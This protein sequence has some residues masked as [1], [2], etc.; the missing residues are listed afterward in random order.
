MIEDF[1]DFGKLGQGFTSVDELEEV[2]LGGE[3][4]SRPTYISSTLS[5]EHKRRLSDLLKEFPDSFAWS[6]TEMPELGRDLV[7]HTLPIK[8]GFKPR[9][10]P[11]RNYNLALL[12]RIKEEVEQLL[13]AGFIRTCRYV[14]WI[15]N[16]VPVEKKNM[17]KIRVC[18]DFYDL[19]RATPKDK[20]AMPVAEDLINKVSGHRMISFLDG[21][22]GYNQIFMVENDVSKNC[23]PGFVGLFK[24]VVMTFGLRN[25][26]ATYQGALNLI[27]HDLIGVLLE[28][29]IDDLV[30]KLAGF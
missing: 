8:K 14:E 2:D 11:V 29:Y 23:C 3:D 17:G 9:K 26:G 27:F 5:G 15:S 10:Q 6:Y 1:Y 24:W 19:N 20:Y 22:A 28:V 13:E 12:V 18:V 4:M 21:N 30:V 25:T 7:E 16:I